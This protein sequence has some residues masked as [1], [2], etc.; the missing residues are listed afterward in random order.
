MADPAAFTYT[1]VGA[2]LRTNLAAS[3]PEGFRGLERRA[4]IGHGDADFDRAAAAVLDWAIQRRSGMR[5]VDADGQDATAV[6]TGQNV[7]L[8][9]PFGPVRIRAAA[10]VAYRVD[11]PNRRGFAYGT[12]PGHPESGEEAFLVERDPDG[13][14]W[15]S[16]R[17]F[18]RP[19]RWY[20]WA[21]SPVLR[22]VQEIYTRRYLRV[23]A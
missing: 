8:R 5:V 18:S 12:L 23:L 1:A 19:S 22:V 20:W 2:T 6:V 21:V 15:I 10:R 11:E 3:S 17:A 14:V 4:L 13:S 16:I 9:I 7:T